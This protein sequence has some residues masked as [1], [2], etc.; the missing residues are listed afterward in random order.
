[1]DL[2]EDGG[3]GHVRGGRLEVGEGNVGEDLCH[4]YGAQ[5]TQDSEKRGSNIQVDSKSTDLNVTGGSFSLSN[6]RGPDRQI[7]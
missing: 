6:F 1:M 2:L 3:V 5:K 7:P 4:R